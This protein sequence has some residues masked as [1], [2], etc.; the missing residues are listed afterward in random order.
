MSADVR[1]PR[2]AAIAESFRDIKKFELILE[3]QESRTRLAAGR[4]E[5]KREDETALS[6]FQ[7]RQESA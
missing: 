7:R 1:Q 2:R 6:V 4:R 5:R 3:R